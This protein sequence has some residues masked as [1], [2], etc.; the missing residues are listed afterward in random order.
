MDKIGGLNPKTQANFQFSV[1]DFFTEKGAT[2]VTPGLLTSTV[3]LYEPERMWSFVNSVSYC[4]QS[5]NCDPSIK[6]WLARNQ[7]N[8]VNTT[9]AVTGQFEKIKYNSS[10]TGDKVE[11]EVVPYTKD[12]PL[13]GIAILNSSK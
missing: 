6:K 2:W 8:M 11:K 12:V 9:T 10:I 13:P 1:A 7:K 4:I 3:E 5:N